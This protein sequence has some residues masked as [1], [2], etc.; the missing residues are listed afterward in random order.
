MVAPP[1][2]DGAKLPN[3][4]RVDDDE[5]ARCDGEAAHPERLEASPVTVVAGGRP[6]EDDGGARTEEQQPTQRSSSSGAA[7]P[8][9]HRTQHHR[10]EASPTSSSSLMRNQLSFHGAGDPRDWESSI[11]AMERA[12]ASGSWEAVC[13]FLRVP[14]GPLLHT[15][16]YING[17]ELARFETAC[18]PLARTRMCESASK[19]AVVASVRRAKTL[20]RAQ[21]KRGEAALHASSSSSSSSQRGG[22]ITTMCHDKAS[23]SD[24][25][26]AAELVMPS[27]ADIFN[28]VRANQSW[29]R[30]TGWIGSPPAW[31]VL[32]DLYAATDGEAWAW[33]EGWSSSDVDVAR[34]FGV[35]AKSGR[36]V[37]VALFSNSLRGELPPSLGSL[38][39]LREL[40]LHHNSLVGE[41]PATLGNLTRLE[42][43]DL[44]A[45]RL[46]GPLAPELFGRWTRLQYLNLSSNR[47]SGE[48]PAALGSATRLEALHLDHN[49]FTGSVPAEIGHLTRLEVF[50]ASHCWLTGELPASMKDLVALRVLFLG[51]NRLSGTL[52]ALA[53]LCRRARTSPP[54]AAD[55]GDETHHHHPRGGDDDH[56]G[57]DDDPADTSDGGWA[58]S[59]S[60]GE[61]REVYAND[62]NL[63]VSRVHP[64]LRAHL[65]VLF[66]DRNRVPEAG[67][68]RPAVVQRAGPPPPVCG[69]GV[70]AAA[71]V[72]NR[73]DDDAA[74][75]RRVRPP[76]ATFAPDLRRE[77][78]RITGPLLSQAHRAPA[79]GALRP[80]EERDDEDDD[81][82]DDPS[83]GARRRHA[84]APRDAED[85][86]WG[87]PEEKSPS[88]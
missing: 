59:S 65:A 1:S 69:G 70:V 53:P 27:A 55:W 6:A 52:D 76:L 44:S 71:R 77:V 2:P 10:D 4:H 28:R 15:L 60:A 64:A 12:Q 38:A 87:Y 45:N 32:Q 67:A 26:A 88:M 17:I 46:N 18:P 40:L 50:N 24:G 5:A 68:Q 79:C 39:N 25:G 16:S 84:D 82:D 29:K 54:V 49:S 80:H 22:T 56:P 83:A 35:T 33:S 14:F 81:D 11:V 23:S 20:R 47:L 62:N 48:L 73:S 37:G 30:L 21:Q 61:L 13:S 36:V 63:D 66:V 42:T 51:H 57:G 8:A 41:I 43:L 85:T 74:A 86:T 7:A 72:A 58:S 31:C 3:G 75:A 9:S 19:A 34:W 78:D